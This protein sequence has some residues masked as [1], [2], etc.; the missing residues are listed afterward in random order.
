VFDRWENFKKMRG[1]IENT[2]I[3]DNFMVALFEILPGFSTCR[4]CPFPEAAGFGPAG[5]AHSRQTT[6]ELFLE[7]IFWLQRI[8]VTKI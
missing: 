1:A 4:I 3:K 6:F 7:Q 2:C 8:I 5:Y